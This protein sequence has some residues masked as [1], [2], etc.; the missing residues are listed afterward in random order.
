[1]K[2]Y[3]KD[4]S[5]SMFESDIDLNITIGNIATDFF[6]LMGWPTQDNLGRG[7]RAIVEYFDPRSEQYIRLR[8]DQTLSEINIPD[9]STISIHPESIAGCFTSN[10]LI[11]LNDGKYL[12]ISQI[13]VGDEIL[14]GAINSSIVIPTI[15]H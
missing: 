14:S 12:P 6:E 1:M 2:L 5:G 10:T 7:Q 15:V 9:G 4:D 8:P 13:K 11:S 3:V